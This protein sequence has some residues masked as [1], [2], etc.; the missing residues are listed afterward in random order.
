MRRKTMNEDLNGVLDKFHQKVKQEQ[1]D[2][3]PEELEGDELDNIS[4]GVT[5]AEGSQSSGCTN[6]TCGSIGI[7]TL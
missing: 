5:Q 6:A 1:A 2:A 3:K 7:G 4:G